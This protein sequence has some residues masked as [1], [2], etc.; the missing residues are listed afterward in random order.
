[1]M[2]T[3]GK[4]HGKL[5]ETLL[6]QE[7][8]YVAWMLGCESP[9]GPLAQAQQEAVRLIRLFDCRPLREQCSG[10][11]CGRR[12][13]RASVYI[14]SVSPRWWCEECDPYQAGATGGKLRIVQSYLDAVRHA[15]MFFSP[16]QAGM[17]R[18][19]RY[20]AEA[21]GLPSRLTAEVTSEFFDE[22]P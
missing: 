8:A 1:M 2:L 4:H 10:S 13:T 19:I 12:A 15:E 18:L 9:S 7:P 6:I 21:K 14:G 3:F 17:R 5:L 20:L 16:R 11:G 22:C